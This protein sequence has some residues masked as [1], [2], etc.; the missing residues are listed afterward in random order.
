VGLEDDGFGKSQSL[1]RSVPR[2][3][4]NLDQSIENQEFYL[5]LMSSSKALANEETIITSMNI[6]E[7]MV[8]I[9]KEH[10]VG[11]L[12][13]AWLSEML[14]ELERLC[15]IGFQERYAWDENHWVSGFEC[16]NE[17]GLKYADVLTEIGYDPGETK[18]VLECRWHTTDQFSYRLYS[19]YDLELQ[20]SN[21][22]CEFDIVD[23]CIAIQVKLCV[24]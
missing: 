21:T 7:N 10:H 20:C 5:G 12:M 4:I 19:I 3:L 24:S 8:K 9:R 1:L 23:D 16:I 6:R 14:G 18:R 13:R 15:G 22:I 17:K 2:R 11:K